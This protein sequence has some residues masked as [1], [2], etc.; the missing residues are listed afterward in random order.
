MLPLHNGISA[1]LPVKNGQKYLTS[2]LPRILGMLHSGDELIVVNDGSSDDSRELIEQFAILD[3]RINLINT[4]GV[5]L[6][7]ALN[8]GVQASK[9]VWIARFDV[10]DSSFRIDRQRD[11]IADEVVLIFSDYKFVSKT[12]A[13]L[14]QVCSAILPSACALSLI[15]SQRTAHPVVLLNKEIFQK[16]GGYNKFDFPVEDLALWLKMS[17]FGKI[18]SDSNVLLNYQLSIGSISAEN[19]NVQ[20]LKKNQL[21]KNY[22][23]WADWQEKCLDEFNE[24]VS[25][26]LSLPHAPKRIFLHLRDLII[27]G[28]L[29]GIKV[30][31]RRLLLD[32][33][34]LLIIKLFLA[35]IHIGVLVIYRRAFRFIQR[36]SEFL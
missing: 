14:G 10:D 34:I 15:T 28:K 29:T 7:N 18:I 35:G 32:L 36:Y 17:T 33:G 4:T 8:L 12:G 11:L 19:R 26:Y 24:T 3:S 16:C 9:N 1:L 23:M 25:I 30:P 6:V 21:V 13:S 22:G 2:L 20:K 27:A 31:I 5:G